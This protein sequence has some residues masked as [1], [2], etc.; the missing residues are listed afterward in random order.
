MLAVTM[1]SIPSISSKREALCRQLPEAFVQMLAE[2]AFADAWALG[3]PEE[4]AV[5]LGASSVVCC[6][7]F[8]GSERGLAF[9]GADFATLTDLAA[10]YHSL[11]D[12]MVDDGTRLEFLAEIGTLLIREMGAFPDVSAHYVP[13]APRMPMPGELESLWADPTSFTVGFGCNGDGWMIFAV[14]LDG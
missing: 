12:E 7:P 1:T 5:A 3:S 4:N 2:M 8:S 13:G 14:R 11:P 9:V 6:V 10:G